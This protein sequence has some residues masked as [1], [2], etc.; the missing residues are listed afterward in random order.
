VINAGEVVR[1]THTEGGDDNLRIVHLPKRPS[2]D[3]PDFVYANSYDASDRF[4]PLATERVEFE[5]QY[6]QRQK[7]QVWGGMLSF[8]LLL[9][10]SFIA[11]VDPSFI[12]SLS[13]RC[14]LLFSLLSVDTRGDLTFQEPSYM[15]FVAPEY[16]PDEPVVHSTPPCLPTLSLCFFAF[17]VHRFTQLCLVFP[18]VKALPGRGHWV[19]P[20]KT[21][22]PV[23]SSASE[24][25]MTPTPPPVEESLPAADEEPANPEATVSP[26]VHI[27]FS[28]FSFLA[29]SSLPAP[30]SFLPFFHS[31][32]CFGSNVF[33]HYR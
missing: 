28:F 3:Q 23:V 17:A 30:L 8:L 12:Q 31:P 32:A 26:H 6:A 15:E 25:I 4:T 24:P 20:A 5:D 19:L 27:L 1:K 29:C 16:Q 9:L 10:L 21:K 33:A 2:P 7:K 11:V 13:V 22:T 18:V 14:S